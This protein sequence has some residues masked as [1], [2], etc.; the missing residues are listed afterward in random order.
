MKA[1]LLESPKH[2]TNGDIPEPE[3]PGPGDA[4]GRVHRIGICGTDISG[5]LGK[6]PFFSYPRIPGHELGVEVVEVGEGVT[7]PVKN[8][9]G[10]YVADERTLDELEETGRVV[11]Y[12]E[13]GNPNGSLR[14]IAGICNE[15]GNVLGLMPH[16]EHAVEDLTGPGT[17]GLRFFTA[18]LTTLGRAA[19]PRAAKG[20]RSGIS[21]PI[22][23]PGSL[24]ARTAS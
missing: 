16:P 10:A 6:M 23:E 12:Y 7:I 19:G 13:G 11:A 20:R 8:G 9:E 2:V 18:I 5:Y 21:L 1:L 24:S 15:A 17:D 22:T 4:L 3:S 14:D